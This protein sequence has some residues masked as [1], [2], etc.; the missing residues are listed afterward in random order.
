MCKPVLF[1]EDRKGYW[2]PNHLKIKWTL[3]ETRFL[4][5]QGRRRI[6]RVLTC[7]PKKLTKDF[8][9]F[10][11]FLSTLNNFRFILYL[12]IFDYGLD[13][14]TESYTFLKSAK[15]QNIINLLHDCTFTIFLIKYVRRRY[16]Q[17]LNV[18]YENRPDVVK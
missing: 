2:F 10:Y 4:L 8:I 18:E 6:E 16:F 17:E 9:S 5:V 12:T 14:Q 3:C 1:W 7:Y 15:A 13:H 11:I